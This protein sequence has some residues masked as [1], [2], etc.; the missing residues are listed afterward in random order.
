[1]SL[2]PFKKKEPN[3]PLEINKNAYLS[4]L[5]GP[6]PRPP[7]LSWM[8]PDGSNGAVKG[9]AAPLDQGASAEL[10]TQPIANGSYALATPDRKTLIQADLFELADVPEFRLPTDPLAQAT[11]DLV[12][13]RLVRAEEAIGLATLVMKGY[14]PNVYE[15]IRFLLDSA[16][17]LADQT[18]GVVA[19]PLAE[20]Y[21]LPTELAQPSPLD[22]RI[23]FRDI[24]AIKAIRELGDVW[25]STR[26]MS[27]FNLPEYEVYGVAAGDVT[28]VGEILIVTAQEALLGSPVPIDR[29]VDTPFGRL[30]AK[31]GTRNRA[32]WGSRPTIELILV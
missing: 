30:T 28:R 6:S 1:M 13:E 7:V 22:P 26:G 31:L 25:V 3:A 11:V 5:M 17:R 2:W 32:Q 21:R 16:G 20:T 4:V 9:F 29:T 23:D 10:L 24:G 15:S 27:K 14:S 19:D 8:N 12:G 18:E